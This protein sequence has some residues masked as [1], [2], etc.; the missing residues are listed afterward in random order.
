MAEKLTLQQ[1]Q[2]VDNRGG[3]LLVS[4]AAGSGKTKVLVDRL[5]KYILD[6]VDPANIDEFLIITYTKAAASELRA[7]IAG[8]LSEKIAVEPGNHHL[9]R[10]LQRLYLTKIST[11]HSF[12]SDI[13]REYAYKLDISGD[14]RVADENE[15][16]QLR[17]SAMEQILE[18][19]YSSIG[20]DVNFQAF[21]D[22]QGLGRSDA[23]VPEIID[24][25]YDS[26]M[27][28][29]DPTGWCRRCVESAEVE[30]LT[31][32][33]QT[34]WGKFLIDDL[35]QCLDGQIAA[36]QVCVK[37]V[38]SL[39]GLEKPADLLRDT[40]SQL[41]YLRESKTWNDVHNR[42]NIEYGRLVFPK[43]SDDPSVTT[44]VKAVRKACKDLLDRKLKVFS[45]TAEQ[46]LSD[47][48]QSTAA[49]KA[50]IE[51]V[52]K[53]A[54]AYS[55]M[56]RLRRVL[57]FS[58]LEHKTLD[59]L[60]GKNRSS[61]TVAA[62]EIGRRYRE[63]M[64]DEYQDTNSVQDAIFSALTAEKKNLFMVG[65]V[66][67]SIYQFRLADPDIFLEKYA[68]YDDVESARPGE[69]RKVILSSNFRSG[70]GV[71]EGANFVF[72]RCMSQAVGGIDYGETEA[73]KE[74]IPHIALGEPEVELY[75]IRTQGETYDEEA[76]FVA[77]RITQLLTE[78]HCVR[79]GESL[80][81]IKAEDI[82]ILLRSP[83]SVGG[84]FVRALEQRGI[85][86]TSG[87][88][89]DLLASPEV[90]TLRSIL[91]VTGN[92]RQDIPLIAAMASPVFGFTAEDLASI[93]SADK[94]SSIYDTLLQSDNR[95]VQTFLAI[96]T[97]LR[98]AAAVFTLPDFLEKLFLLTRLDTVY[99]A[100]PD[101]WQ[102]R[103]N[104]QEIYQLAIDF[105][106]T[107]RGDLDS[108]LAHLDALEERGLPSSAQEGASDCVTVMSIHKSKGLE[109]PVVFLCGLSR[110]FNQESLRAQVLCHKDMGI[111]LSCVDTVN[112]LRYPT[113]SK[114]AIAAKISRDSLSEEMRVLYVAM[115]RPKD[116]LIMTYASDSLDKDITDIASR[117]NICNSTCM[118]SDVNCPGRWVLYSALQRI[119]AGEFFA[120]GAKPRETVVRLPAWKIKVID[121]F[122]PDD[123]THADKAQKPDTINDDTVI[124]IKQALEFRY[125]HTAATHTPSK[126][127]ATQKKGRAK[128]QEAAEQAKELLP[129]SR[130]WRKPTFAGEQ[131]RGAAFGTAV[132]T[133][134]QQIRYDRCGSISG[135][136]SELDRI[137][138][139]GFITPE[140]RFAIRSDRIHAFFTT[141]FGTKLRQCENVLREFKFS[142]LDDAQAYEEGL[143]DEQVLLQGVVDCALID[144]TGITV[145]DFKTDYV[146]ADTLEALTAHYK[147]QV[148]TYAAALGRIFRLPVNAKGIYYFHIGSF[149]WL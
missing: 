114:S 116:R 132:H 79:D 8:K 67:Q 42:R 70:G 111:G 98:K 30:K 100:M 81:P 6:P 91:Q 144:E 88:G 97:E 102:A 60:L 85:R 13:L 45:D 90:S 36:I 122:V 10:Q 14:F 22:T 25:V 41:S 126:Q 34:P 129:V 117:M 39:P 146:P 32:P 101:G 89:A 96:V 130:A 83:G 65:D 94:K 138:S 115:T 47:L 92:P 77:E 112:R 64:V 12:C 106:H 80:R 93:R 82:V 148:E 54:Q 141:D 86:C 26:A 57:D 75:G 18:E 27:C 135:V 74:G 105:S 23:L 149:M 44:P 11:V 51:L 73:L 37:D 104:L 95:K 63:I 120:L 78:G 69:G 28:H 147:P 38:S 123:S 16:L 49:A 133:V 40:L 68:A 107:G 145:L 52:E 103:E 109:F 66:K 127:T 46:V 119:E 113:I 4:A 128:D 99:A 76:S 71:I 124:K 136:E 33:V 53:Y 137:A 20:T 15:V 108:F 35:F 121:G 7:K 59:L 58:D 48:E 87:V 2:A 43:K 84:A 140:Q 118:T 21:V 50:L 1:Q 61:I 29:I 139:V 142:I 143:T 110:R 17:A 5:L 55:R 31:D 24:R 9:Q 56:K 62:R 134:M 19:A 125:P 3:K 131:G 72:E